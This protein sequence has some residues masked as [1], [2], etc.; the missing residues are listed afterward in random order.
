MVEKSGAWLNYGSV[1]LG[2]GRE[3]AKKYLVDNPELTAEIKH[4]IL[5]AKGLA[6]A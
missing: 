3:N 1:R 4:K 5:V 6:E 2:Q